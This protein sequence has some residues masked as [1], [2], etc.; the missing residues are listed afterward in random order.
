MFLKKPRAEDITVLELPSNILATILPASFIYRFL[1]FLSENGYS[2]IDAIP[3]P[4]SDQA[5]SSKICKYR[6][7]FPFNV[8]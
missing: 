4:L 1:S 6:A 8:I 7:L 2:D 5:L 3:F